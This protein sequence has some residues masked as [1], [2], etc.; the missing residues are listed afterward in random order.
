MC[1]FCMSYLLCLQLVHAASLSA[2][3]AAS[4]KLLKCQMA[5]ALSQAGEVAVAVAVSVAVDVATWR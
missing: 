3:S 4:C 5:N 2:A 1:V